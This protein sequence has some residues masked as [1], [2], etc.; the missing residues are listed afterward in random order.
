MPSAPRGR[1][2]GAG[3]GIGADCGGASGGSG[4]GGDGGGG[5][6]GFGGGRSAR[7]YLEQGS[8]DIV[9]A[10]DRRGYHLFIDALRGPL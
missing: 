5:L 1:D 10:C 8:I 3:G 9:H 6:L 4:G 2:R 7:G